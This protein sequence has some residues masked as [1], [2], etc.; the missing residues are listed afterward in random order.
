M[1]SSTIPA[2]YIHQSWD[3]MCHDSSTRLYSYQLDEQWFT[4][5][6][7]ILRDALDITPSNDNHPFVA[8][9]SSDAVIEYVN[10]FGYPNTLRNVSAMSVNALYQPWRVVLSMINMCLTSKTARYDRLRHPVL[11]ILWGVIHRTN[12]D[13]AERIWEEYTKKDER[14]IFVMPIPNVILTDDIRSAPYYSGYLEQATK[15]PKPAEALKKVQGRK[16]KPTKETTDAPSP[17]KRTQAGKFGDE[18]ANVQKALEESLK[19]AYLARQGP[20]PLM[21][22]KKMSPVEQYIF[23]RRTPTT[24][25]PSGLAESPSL[26]VELG[27]TDSETDSDEEAGS[28]AGDVA[29]DQPQSSHVVHAGPNLDHMD[30]GIAEASSQPNP[31]QMNQ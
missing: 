1:A 25:K 7:E 23:Q 18:E 14:V 29:V 8:P 19:G 27:L 31:E 30:L 20:L 11:Q 10:T 6:I 26:Y 22:P 17:A 16:C 24:T 13:Y 12:I 28:N 4:I 3:I 2:I 21:T 5:H 15:P 9:P